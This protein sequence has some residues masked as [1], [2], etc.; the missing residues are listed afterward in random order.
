MPRLGSGSSNNSGD[1]AP[2]AHRKPEG[3]GGGGEGS[4]GTTGSER[5]RGS[6]QT[7]VAGAA[8]QAL[9][10]ALVLRLTQWAAE[11]DD[12]GGDSHDDAASGQVLLPSMQLLYVLLAAPAQLPGLAEPAMRR[13][14]PA[15][16]ASLS[17]HATALRGWGGGGEGGEAALR[18]AREPLERCFLRL[19]LLA[20][21]LRAWRRWPV[22]EE[23][24]ETTVGVTDET[25]PADDASDAKSK[26]KST[27][28][29]AV[30]AA[31]RLIQ[32]PELHRALFAF[33]R[34]V[35]TLRE[36]TRGGGAGDDAST[37][38]TSSVRPSGFSA[39]LTTTPAKTGTPASVAAPFFSDA[40]VRAHVPG[41]L[42]ES[43]P[44]LLMEAGLR[45]AAAA[46]A[47]V[48]TSSADGA[49]SAVAAEGTDVV[50]AVLG[51]DRDDTVSDD[52]TTHGMEAWKPLLL[53]QLRPP[54][55]TTGS[56]DGGVATAL[57]AAATTAQAA[58]SGGAHKYA[59]RLLVAV[60]G[61]KPAYRLTRDLFLCGHQLDVLREIAAVDSASGGSFAPAST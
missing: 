15:L 20:V 32:T 49:S 4:G 61:G 1:A 57:A 31:R 59:G 23:E 36:R 38:V 8:H 22:A 6:E 37:V 54:T 24:E 10:G 34:S 60:C 53:A 13:A 27:T 26:S 30:A 7:P 12:G 56:S 44:P 39:L 21:L 17:A 5:E 46:A 41:R 11:A 43:L 2:A 3:G 35:H 14:V 29:H 9:A 50:A 58:A 28:T 47:A 51:D 18:A 25:T 55:A 52:D 33:L 16:T 40:Y 19:M 42:F 45:L 48:T